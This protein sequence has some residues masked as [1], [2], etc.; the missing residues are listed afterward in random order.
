MLPS[1][2]LT[3]NGITRLR[4]DAVLCH[5]SSDINGLLNEGRE[6]ST[7]EPFVN[8]NAVDASERKGIQEPP[9]GGLGADDIF[10]G[11]FA[12]VKGVPL[13]EPRHFYSHS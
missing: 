8:F 5:T 1:V 7:L 3:P 13:C 10:K 4:K 6:A 11:T 9:G 2:E 12:V